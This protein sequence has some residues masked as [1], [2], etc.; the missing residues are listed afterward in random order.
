MTIRFK[1]PFR[2]T[3]KVFHAQKTFLLDPDRYAHFS[4][5]RLVRGSIR[6]D[7]SICHAKSAFSRDQITL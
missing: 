6:G 5:F 1:T 2:M 7:I 4:I 3:I